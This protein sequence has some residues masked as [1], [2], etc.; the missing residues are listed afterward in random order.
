MLVGEFRH[1]VGSLQH[2]PA[3]GHLFDDMG[4]GFGVQSCRDIVDQGNKMRW[5]ADFF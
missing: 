3:Y 4:I 1:L 5:S 2:A